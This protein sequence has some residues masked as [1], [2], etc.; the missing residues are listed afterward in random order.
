MKP[1]VGPGAPSTSQP[2]QSF[3]EAVAWVA[4]IALI[5]MCACWPKQ[6][7]KR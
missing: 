4:V 1:L 6:K 3:E 2:P 7:E 5:V